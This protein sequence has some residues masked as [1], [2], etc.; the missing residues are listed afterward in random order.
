M[1][2]LDLIY[3]VV[4]IYLIAKYRKQVKIAEDW[5]ASAIEV[6]KLLNELKHNAR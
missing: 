3:L 2:G 5:K 1:N 6:N 4:I